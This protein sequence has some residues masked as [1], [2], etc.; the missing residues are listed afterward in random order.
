ME[1]YEGTNN[2]VNCWHCEH[3]E[4]FSD[5]NK[6]QSAICRIKNTRV[7][8]FDEVCE[9]FLLNEAVY[10]KRKIPSYCRHYKEK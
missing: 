7:F 6:N 4:W 2:F 5:D 9:D 1:L 10:T 3:Y 8:A